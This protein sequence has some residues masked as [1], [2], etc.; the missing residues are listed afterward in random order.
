MIGCSRKLRVGVILWD[1]LCENFN[2]RDVLCLA[3][4]AVA[5]PSSRGARWSA[6]GFWWWQIFLVFP[7]TDPGQP[8]PVPNTGHQVTN[9]LPSYT[10][11]SDSQCV[12]V[13]RE[14]DTMS[15]TN[16]FRPQWLRKHEL[17]VFILLCLRVQRPAPRLTAWLA[18][19]NREKRM[20]SDWRE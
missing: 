5:S 9:Q 6:E 14:G 18:S 10:V 15:K 20:A 13:A 7:R 12:T 4:P 8:I 19:L 11:S 1:R 2:V 16:A 17:N 3:C